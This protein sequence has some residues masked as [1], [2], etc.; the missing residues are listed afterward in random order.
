MSSPFDFRIEQNALMVPSFTPEKEVRRIAYNCMYGI[1]Q[2]GVI[3]ELPDPTTRKGII[4]FDLQSLPDLS[5]ELEDAYCVICYI[6]TSKSDRP[7]PKPL[8]P[9][10]K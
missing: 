8:F 3:G 5:N 2:H 1:P 9:E 6:R 4:T 10:I 7:N